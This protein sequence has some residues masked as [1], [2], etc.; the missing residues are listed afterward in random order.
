MSTIAK[1]GEVHIMVV[2]LTGVVVDS[3]AR[4]SL[5]AQVLNRLVLVVGASYK[6]LKR[7]DV[8]WEVL[9]IV[10]RQSLRRDNRGESL[11]GIG[12]G[13]SFDLHNQISLSMTV[14]AAK[15]RL[16]RKVLTAMTLS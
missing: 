9:T 12:K 13:K 6:S 5:A 10:E 16:S 2:D 1:L 11:C 15:S 14:P 3:G 7:V 4:L 8:G